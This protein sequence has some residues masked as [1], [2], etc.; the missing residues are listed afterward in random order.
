MRKLAAMLSSTLCAS[1]LASAAH[2]QTPQYVKT[3]T[4]Q[5]GASTPV[6]SRTQSV[7]DRAE[8]LYKLGAVYA[9]M[10]GSGSA[11]F[12]IFEQP[13]D[14]HMHFRSATVWQGRL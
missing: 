2:A 1:L 10:S 5:P 6:D 3:S 11:V 8:Q 13:T 9:S 14:V 4:A 12:G 7:I